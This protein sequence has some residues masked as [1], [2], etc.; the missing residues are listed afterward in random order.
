MIVRTSVPDPSGTLSLALM[1]VTTMAD[2]PR[3]YSPVAEAFTPFVPWSPVPPAA[4]SPAWTP[5][6]QLIP[7]VRYPAPAGNTLYVPPFSV[8][9]PLGGEEYALLT[10]DLASGQS[11][12][13]AFA[14][15]AT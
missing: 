11:S 10:V 13:L 15:E 14:S 6:D 1:V 2:P 5:P 7:Y 12:A 9:E 8:P 3:A 4:G